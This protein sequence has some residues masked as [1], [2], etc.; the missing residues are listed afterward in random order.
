MI[1]DD[2]DVKEVLFKWMKSKKE[3]TPK[4]K[5]D[6]VSAQAKEW[7]ESDLIH[8][9]TLHNDLVEAD[10]LV[11]AYIDAVFREG[12]NP[13][14]FCKGF[15]WELMQ[16]K[17]TIAYKTYWHPNAW[18]GIELVREINRRGIDMQPYFD[19]YPY[20]DTWIIMEDHRGGLTIEVRPK[21]NLF[22]VK[23]IPKS[24]HKPFKTFARRRNK[25]YPGMHILLPEMNNNVFLLRRD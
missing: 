22:Y 11:Q 16:C 18:D 14:L 8:W 10:F 2:N 17:K 3:I 1:G 19:Q 23:R 5:K 24:L 15:E 12:S 9:R 25:L 7:Q 6:P 13:P 20:T 4:R 21:D